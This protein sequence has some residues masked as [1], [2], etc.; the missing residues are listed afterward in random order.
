MGTYRPLGV[1]QAERP[2]GLLLA[3]P[4]PRNNVATTR[5][6]KR[7]HRPQARDHARRAGR[8]TR[9]RA[10][11]LPRHQP[12]CRARSRRRSTT[13]SESRSSPRSR[14]LSRPSRDG[15][16]RRSPNTIP[17]ITSRAAPSR[18]VV[19]G[20]GC[21]ARRSRRAPRFGG[22]SPSSAATRSGRAPESEP[23]SRTG[24]SSGAHG[25]AGGVE[26]WIMTLSAE[27]D[28]D[29]SRPAAI[30]AGSRAGEDYARADEDVAQR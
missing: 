18:I 28:P 29:P 5:R 23:P 30:G 9:A 7:R 13:R 11:T 26:S 17:A 12:V 15:R 22:A 14:E 19:R 27:S 2:I 10:R 24:R 6:S 20:E 8:R 25:R 4:N 3:F 21:A 1:T 16:I